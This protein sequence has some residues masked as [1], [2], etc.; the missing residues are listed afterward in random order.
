MVSSDSNLVV[1][2]SLGLCLLRAQ[3]K[4]AISPQVANL[5][6]SVL[7]GRPHLLTIPLLRVRGPHQ[8]NQMP[9]P[10]LQS[11][12]TRRC[13]GAAYQHIM[14]WETSQRLVLGKQAQASRALRKG[15]ERERKRR[16]Q[17]RHGSR[18][19]GEGVCVKGAGCWTERV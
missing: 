12:L 17:K 7:H 18:E 15:E 19:R 16:K 8:L 4:S 6:S 5:P 13:L 1:G 3:L 10:G 2:K 9:L 11:L 14:V